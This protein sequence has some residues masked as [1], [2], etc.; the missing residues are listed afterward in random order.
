MDL[1]LKELVDN[2]IYCIQSKH[3]NCI[4]TNGWEF[5]VENTRT[6]RRAEKERSPETL[7]LD[8][9]PCRQTKKAPLQLL[10]LDNNLFDKL[11]FHYYCITAW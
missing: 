5:S 9:S 4:K 7:V 10:C 11:F 8:F 6:L 1:E 3:L 2:A